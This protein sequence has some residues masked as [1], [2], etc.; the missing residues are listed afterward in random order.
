MKI[1]EQLF[2]KDAKRYEPISFYI[3]KTSLEY[4]SYF[5]YERRKYAPYWVV[6]EISNDYP[7]V[8]FVI[9]ASSPDFLCGP[10]GIIKIKNGEIMDSYG[11]YGTDSIRHEIL[12][13]PIKNRED[14]YKWFKH[15]GVEEQ[16]RA[17]YISEF[18]LGW[19]EDSFSDKIIPIEES[20]L[21]LRIEQ[22]KEDYPQIDWEEQP[23]F[24]LIPSFEE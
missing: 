2:H 21:R 16:L 17:N 12:D 22:S 24:R 19:C 20:G 4:A 23:K 13:A 9:L 7:K 8:S 18:P 15:G 14:I 1:G 6:Q 5:T 10:G 11:I 3:A